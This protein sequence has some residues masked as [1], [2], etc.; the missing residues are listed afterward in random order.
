MSYGYGQ[1]RYAA[2]A[3]PPPAYGH[4]RRSAPPG[5]HVLAILQ[6]LAGFLTLGV[7]ALFAWAAVVLANGTYAD[8]SGTPIA[9]DLIDDDGAAMIFGVIAG[10]IAF[11]GL[12]T[13]FLGRKLQRGRQWARVVV[14]M[15]SMLSLVSVVTSLALRQQVDVSVASLAYPVLCLILLNTGAA[16]SWFRYRTW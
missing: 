4:A 16:R 13:I 1:S 12:L 5:V 10:V 3:P 14:L 9:D 8:V 6:Y 7:A 2:Y 15:L 11:F